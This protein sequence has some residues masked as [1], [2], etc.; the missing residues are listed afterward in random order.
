[1]IASSDENQ[2][3]IVDAL[4]SYGFS[5][6]AIIISRVAYPII[7]TFN[8]WIPTT[9][10]KAVF[11]FGILFLGILA[12]FVVPIIMVVWPEMEETAAKAVGIKGDE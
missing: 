2:T 5:L 10:G 4:K 7:E 12:L 6:I 11:G 1:M 3:S 9:Y 8:D